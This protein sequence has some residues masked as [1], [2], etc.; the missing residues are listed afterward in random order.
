[1]ADKSSEADGKG[2]PRSG[3][4]VLDD[5]A[6]ITVGG[7]PIGEYAKKAQDGKPEAAPTAAKPAKPGM[8]GKPLR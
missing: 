2:G 3:R 6:G 5:D 1:M 4:F 8:L 7:M